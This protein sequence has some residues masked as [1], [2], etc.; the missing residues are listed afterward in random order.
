MINHQECD[1][2]NQK[3]TRGVHV[4]SNQSKKIKM[5]SE[6]G[7]EGE[8]KINEPV[9][10]TSNRYTWEELSKYGERRNA[11]VAVRGKVS[12][13]PFCLLIYAHSIWEGW[14]LL[15]NRETSVG[16]FL[17]SEWPSTKVLFKRKMFVHNNIVLIS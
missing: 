7:E 3:V 5:P 6:F 12:R 1:G 11:H 17:Y 15:F 8:Q 4:R 16:L 13:T 14:V 10:P 9:K 2:T